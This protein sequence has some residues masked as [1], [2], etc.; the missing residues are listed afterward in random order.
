MEPTKGFALIFSQDLAGLG[1]QTFYFKNRIRG[2]AFYPVYKKDV[3]LRLSAQTGHIAGLKNK[4]VRI[5]DSFFVGGDDLRG[6]DSYGVG[7]RSIKEGDAIGGKA[8]YTG[9]VELSFPIGPSKDMGIKGFVFTDFGSL[10]SPETKG[11][12]KSKIYNDHFMRASYGA[13]INW[14]SA[15]GNITIDYGIPFR[16][17]HYDEK[18]AFRI[19]F[20]TRF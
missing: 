11:F 2:L 5:N 10:F 7:P 9:N 18:R 16:K 19:S 17:K 6:F 1:G 20:G 13:G 4:M 3:I 15:I 12:D 8:F 14:N